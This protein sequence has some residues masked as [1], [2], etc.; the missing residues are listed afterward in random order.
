MSEVYHRL[1]AGK[2]DGDPFDRHVFA[3]ILAHGIGESPVPLTES[4]GLGR[5]E[6]AHLV[7][8]LFPGA[9]WLLQGLSDNCGT[10]SIEEP[11]LRKLLMDN[12]TD[13]GAH[14]ARW[15]A[16]MVARRSLRPDHLWQGLG[17]SSRQD[18]SGL[19]TRH[20]RP[21]AALNVRDMKWKKFFYRQMCED[22]GVSV[23]KSPVCDSCTDFTLC[24]GPEE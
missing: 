5:T 15:L 12:A 10:D 13:P 9:D 18:L 16:A 4:V 1:M 11:D 7:A 23:C 14:E 6:L 24:Y 2:G 21:L 3:C 22:E 8:C 20:F 19:L 17:L